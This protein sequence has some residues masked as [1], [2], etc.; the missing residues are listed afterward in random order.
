[1]ETVI[2]FFVSFTLFWYK[3]GENCIGYVPLT[4]R[5]ITL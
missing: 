1:M 4:L 3:W 5:E 2:T